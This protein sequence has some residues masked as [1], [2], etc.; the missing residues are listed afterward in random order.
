MPKRLAFR[1][2]AISGSGDDGQNSLQDVHFEGLLYQ[3]WG[4]LLQVPE[5]TRGRVLIE[6][7]LTLPHFPEIKAAAGVRFKKIIG[8][9]SRFGSRRLQHPL[10]QRSE[11]VVLSNTRHKSCNH[12]QFSHRCSTSFILRFFFCFCPSYFL[13]GS[14][15]VRPVSGSSRFCIAMSSTVTITSS[16]GFTYNSRTW[17][18]RAVPSEVART[19][20]VWTWGFP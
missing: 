4:L 2:G 11:F 20:W 10:Q 5:V 1:A 8:L 19:T 3:L 15:S 18:P 16:V 12:S 13:T 7:S 17:P 9:A 14:M 6:S